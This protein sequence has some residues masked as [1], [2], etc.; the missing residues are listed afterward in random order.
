MRAVIAMRDGAE[1][2]EVARLVLRRYSED[3][4]APLLQIHGGVADSHCRRRRAM[5]SLLGKWPAETLKTKEQGRR[6]GGRAPMCHTAAHKCNYLIINDL[7]ADIAGC[8][9]DNISTTRRSPAL[10]GWQ[11]LPVEVC[12]L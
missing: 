5:Q 1:H 11:T 9:D 4:V 2:P 8:G 12:S 10:L 7:L 6:K 3:V